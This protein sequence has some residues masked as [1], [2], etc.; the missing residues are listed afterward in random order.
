MCMDVTLDGALQVWVEVGSPSA[1]RLHKAAKAAPRVVVVTHHDAGLLL[2]EVAGK[3]IHR[4]EAIEV[5]ALAPAF[6]DGIAA[7]IGERGTSLALTV[8]EG[9]LYVTL[10]GASLQSSLERLSLPT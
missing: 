6:L 2:R 9:E 1:E 5:L 3:R 4:A 10:P 8:S 7:H